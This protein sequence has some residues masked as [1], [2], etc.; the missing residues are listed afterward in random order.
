MRA[1]AH[2]V[3]DADGLGGTRLERLYGEVPLLLRRTGSGEVHLVGGAAGPLGGDDLLVEIE[4]G[5]GAT[6]RLHTVAASIALPGASGA[7]SRTTVRAR[8]AAGGRLEWLPE[9]LIAAHGC[10]HTVSS[11]VELEPGAALVWREELVCGRDGEESGAAALET[12]ARLGGRTLL[13]Q[14]VAVGPAAAA[15]DGP[16]VLGAARA[17]G[18]LLIVDP[19]WTDA[20]APTSTVYGDTAAAM[21]LAGPAVLV[22]ATGVDALFLRRA[23]DT[24]LDH[25]HSVSL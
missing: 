12:R 9:P 18:G 7:P 15:W 23:L 2:L 6:V 22:T 20:G 16:A 19:T 11:T 3:A 13:A 24:A 4:V 21:P 25:V 8:V 14:R 1:R 17:V 5:A 10:Q